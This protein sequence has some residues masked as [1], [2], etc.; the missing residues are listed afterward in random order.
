MSIAANCADG[1]SEKMS[2]TVGRSMAEVR[3]GGVVS[4]VITCVG[5]PGEHEEEPF[6]DVPAGVQAAGER[7]RAR[8]AHQ[9]PASFRIGR[10]SG[11]RRHSVRMAKV[12]DARG[13]TVESGRDAGPVEVRASP[14]DPGLTCPPRLL[15]G[16]GSACQNAKSR[17]QGPESLVTC[18]ALGS[19]RGEACSRLWGGRPL[20]RVTTRSGFSELFTLN[21]RGYCRNSSSFRSKPPF[22]EPKDS[23]PIRV[24]RKA[25][26]QL[27]ILQ[28]GITPTFESTPN[29][30]QNTL[31]SPPETLNLTLCNGPK[32]GYRGSVGGA[33]W[34]SGLSA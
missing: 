24:E 33:Q 14:R 19:L 22:V 3:G 2:S 6:F 8:H 10:R 11:K 23:G 21:V 18:V 28:R 9:L 32:L 16:V 4:W 30:P 12:G 1:L 26:R 31:D 15:R 13:R 20:L 34:E 7:G 5:A 17:E 27:Q 29:T 25:I